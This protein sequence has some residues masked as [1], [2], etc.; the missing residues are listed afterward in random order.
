M[1]I[2]GLNKNIQ[3]TEE[4]PI[5]AFKNKEISCFRGTKNKRQGLCIGRQGKK[6]Q[7]F[8]KE[9]NYS[10]DCIDLNKKFEPEWIQICNLEPKDFVNISFPTFQH[11]LN[12]FYINDLI[13]IKNMDEIDGK[14]IIKNETS[15]TRSFKPVTNQIVNVINNEIII[16]K[17][18]MLMVGYF[19]AEGHISKDLSNICFTFSINETSY[20]QF[21]IDY[22]TRAFG[23][24]PY[25][26]VNRDNSTNVIISS[27]IIAT[28]MYEICG[29]GFNTKYLKDIVMFADPE[30]QKYLLVGVIRGDGCTISNGYQLVLSNDK[31][32]N[33]L[34]QISLRCGL[35]PHMYNPHTNPLSTTQ[36]YTIVYNHLDKDFIN[37]VDKNTHKI[38]FLS[39]PQLNNRFWYNNEYYMEIKNVS[40][41]EFEGNVYNIEVS[42][43]HSYVVNNISVHNCFIGSAPDNIEGIFDSYKEMSLLSKFGGGIGWDWNEVRCRSSVIDNNV[44]AAGGT[45]PWLKITNDI[46]IAVDQLGVRKGAIAVYLEPWHMDIKEFL[47]LKKNSGEE[48]LRA[49]DIF[50]ALWINDLFMERVKA[51][52]EWTL[53]DPYQT[54]ELS[55][56][57]GDAFKTQYLIR[58]ND[59]KVNKTVIKAKDLWKQV[60]TNYFES[61]NPFLCFKDTAN[62]TNPNSH[63]GHIRSS[64]LCTEIFQNTSPNIYSVKVWVS[65]DEYFIIKEGELALTKNEFLDDPYIFGKQLTVG[66]IVRGIVIGI[67]E[68]DKSFSVQLLPEEYQKPIYALEKECHE[69][70]TAVCNLASINLSRVNTKED[71]ERV[72]KI[73]M[74]MLDNVVDLNFYPTKKAKDTNLKSRAVGLGVMGEAEMLASKGIMFGSQEHFEF[75]D[76]IMEMVSF[77]AIKGSAEIAVEKGSYPNF[78]GSAWY[79]GILPIDRANTKAA[80]LTKNNSRIYS[81]EEYNK[82][83][84]SVRNGMRNGYLMAIA[85]TSSISILVG[86]TQAIEPIYKKKFF[87]ENMSG[88]IP[89][90]AP[91]LSPETWNYYPSAFDIEQMNL[92]KAASV[93]QKWIDQGQSTNVFMRLDKASGKYL[94]DIYMLAWE[95]G[96]KSTYYLRSQSPEAK[97][98]S[99]DIVDRSIECMGCQ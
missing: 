55:E 40:T 36:C 85:P 63:V 43:T 98:E 51:D 28:L 24:V 83:R 6:D 86:T 79:E 59:P 53:F 77:N 32:I 46:A 19:L 66:D 45:T 57:Y 71:I 74:N 65:E 69:G 18:F 9:R 7:C 4:H 16:D 12:K 99:D 48:R 29:T 1:E 92:I 34:F 96:L 84:E 23:I 38:N 35:S 3:A 22:F 88:L 68:E 33:Q 27:K 93:R 39:K 15:S 58:E 30:I 26:Q 95:Y 82:L 91:K 64:N 8:K 17:D 60:L 80:E 76:G 62:R 78:N 70:E 90:V 37:L 11:N 75:I 54:P 5:K 2:C 94:N 81:E 87:E 97:K 20:Q 73:A 47:D 61:G 49:H 52:A 72:T 10:N 31:L 50:P 41:E 67:N 89:V 56:L 42:N 13:G 25:L 44:N 14:L 21:I